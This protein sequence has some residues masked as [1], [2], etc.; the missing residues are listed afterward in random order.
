MNIAPP[1]PTS[2]SFTALSWQTWFQ[3]VYQRMAGPT[4]GTTT[5]RPT[6]F[7][8]QGRVYFDT[9]LGKPVFY[10]GPGWVDATGASV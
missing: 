10:K 9:T 2:D 1:P 4:S 3:N 7:L 5:N 6:K 8:Y